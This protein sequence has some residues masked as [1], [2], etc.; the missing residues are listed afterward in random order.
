MKCFITGMLGALLA[1]IAAALLIPLY[2]DYRSRAETSI[3]LSFSS[4]IKSQIAQNAI[5]DKT[6]S[7]SG[8]G[9]KIPVE[10]RS[11]PVVTVTDSGIIIM[12]G[13]KY[14]QVLTLVPKLADNKVTWSCI[15]GPAKDVPP[16]CRGN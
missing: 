12:Q 5:R 1:L 2:G 4:A 13:K 11:S 3:W 8:H 9:V 10:F 6:L 15:G 16:F 7:N 14:G